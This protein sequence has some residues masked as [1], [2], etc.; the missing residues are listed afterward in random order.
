[1]VNRP[2]LDCGT[3]SPA[4]RCEACRKP[5]DNQRY[6]KRGTTTQRGYGHAYQQRRPAVL[7]GA[8]H[9]VTC[10]EEFTE[11]NPATT[12]HITD[13]RGLPREHRRESAATADLMPQCAGCNY[14]WGRAGMHMG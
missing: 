9:C 8:T 2:C 12:G 10:G 14:G 11:D 7:D 5:R 1:M 4:S 3:L 13:L 6:A